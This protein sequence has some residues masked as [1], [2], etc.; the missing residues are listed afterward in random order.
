LFKPVNS[1]QAADNTGASPSLDRPK[2][3]CRCSDQN[4]QNRQP[5]KRR[6]RKRRPRKKRQRYSQK[7]A[8]ASAVLAL[9]NS[10][11][12]V[13]DVKEHLTLLKITGVDD[14][15][16]RSCLNT[17]YVDGDVARAVRLIDYQEKAAAGSIVSYNQNV[18]MLGAENRGSVTCYLDSLLFALFAKLDAFEGMLTTEFDD[19]PRKKL[20]T[21]LRL[22]VNLLRSG[23]LIHT[24]IVSSRSWTFRG[25]C[26]LP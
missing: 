13:Q 12:Q 24:D 17:R 22:W 11:P 14:V 6:P 16:I 25:T 26:S 9:T 5:K 8:P 2:R 10:C 19:A 23:E 4:P 21:L 20:V 3:F 15:H 18:Q 7:A 1:G